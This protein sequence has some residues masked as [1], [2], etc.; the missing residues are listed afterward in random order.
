LRFLQGWESRTF[1]PSG[2]ALSSH[3]Q[4]GTK[5]RAAGRDG[6][7]EQERNVPGTHPCKKR[8]GG[9]ASPYQIASYC[10]I[11]DKRDETFEWLGKAYEAHD[12]GLVAI[13]TDSDFDSLHPIR[14]LLIFSAA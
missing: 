8:K 10:A 5:V 9:A 14:G 2:S 4:T 3:A 1:V 11:L 6:S 7:E 13:K 12:S